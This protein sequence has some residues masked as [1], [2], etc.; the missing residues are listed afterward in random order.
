MRNII[1]VSARTA[2]LI[3]ENSCLMNVSDGRLINSLSDRFRGNVSLAVFCDTVKGEK[4]SCEVRV[5]KIYALPFPFSYNGGVKNSYRI[6]KILKK[7]EQ[8]NDVIVIQLPFLSII[9]IFFLRKP[10][11][12]HVCANVLT[13]VKNPIKYRG[14]KRIVA[15]SF[16]SILHSSFKILFDNSKN[17][18]IVNG[19][20]LGILY[21]DYD[22]K[23]VVSS[24]VY[25][26]EIISIADVVP[27][28]AEGLF[29]LLFI[30]RPSLEKGYDVLLKAFE[31]LVKKNYNV[32][33]VVVGAKKEELDLLGKL[34]LD[35]EVLTKI[36][37]RGFMPWGDEFKSVIR[38]SHCLIMSSISEGTPRVLIE[39]RALGCP[40]V[41]TNVGG[42]S[43][44]VTHNE[45]GIL[46]SIGAENE[47][48]SSIVRL[49][50]NEE[51][52]SKLISNGLCRVKEFTVES[53][54]IAMNSEIEKLYEA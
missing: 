28:P 51:L 31:G 7:A 36:N 8:E 23:V 53:F 45:D 40:I 12:F 32:A 52:R 10:I 22:P 27:R 4:Y 26:D 2:Y 41:A 21:T 18:V 13:A 25:E 54:S 44:S 9:P 42:V 20:E 15:I 6:Y 3:N 50:N 46:V 38:N 34:T 30:G 49:I 47:I 19:K 1:F 5:N 16:A 37:C 39:A 48:E 24:G 29:Q 14:L 35:K 17:R 33:L 43:S 11:L